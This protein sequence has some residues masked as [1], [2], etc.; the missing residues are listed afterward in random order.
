MAES[1][2][3]RGLYAGAAFA[4]SGGV[5]STAAIAAQSD[6]PELRDIVVSEPIERKKD[7]EVLFEADFVSRDE[8]TGPIVAE[9]NVRAFFG[10]RFLRADRLIYYPDTDVVIAD[11]NVSITDEKLETVFA[12]RVELTGDLRD[13]LATNFSALLAQ[14]ARLASDSA[15]RE[16]GAKTRLR[17]A[18][19]TACS[20]C[21]DEGEGKI[22]TWRLKALRVVRDEERRVLRFHHAFFELKGVP[23]LYTPLIQGPDPSVERQ[24]GFLSPRFGTSSLQ[25]FHFELPYYLAISNS[26]DATFF[27]RYTTKDG[28]LWQGEYRRRDDNAYQVLSGSIIDFDNVEDDPDA[29]SVRWHIFGKGHRRFGDNF[30]IGYDVERTSDDNFLRR[31][32]ILRR[33]DLRREIDTT[34]SNR[35]RSN[36]FAEWTN[37]PHSLKAES[38][39]FQ[40]LRRSDVD[41]LT[42]YVLPQIDYRHRGFEV[43]GGTARLNANFARLQRTEGADYQR[44][45]ASAHWSADHITKSGHKL[46]AFA[47]ARGDLFTYRDIDQGT[48]ATR[49]A[50]V[51][52]KAD[53]ETKD[54]DVRIVP[55]VGVEWSY[56]LAKQSKNARYFIEPRV[57]LVASPANV[58]DGTA[59]NEDSR[60]VEFDFANLF[61][62]NKSTGY[63]ALEDGQR[64]NVGVAASAELDAGVSIV[65]EIGQQFRLQETNA[66]N[67]GADTPDEFPN[68]LG[69]TRSDI[70]GSLNIKYRNIVG[71]NSRFRFD[72]GFGDLKRLES[73]AYLSLW[74][75]SGNA[76]YLRLAAESAGDGLNREEELTTRV[77]LRLTDHWQAGFGWRED[78]L[79]NQTIDQNFSIAYQDDCALFEIAYRRDRTLD[80]DGQTDDAFLVRFTLKSLVD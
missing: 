3:T 22:P 42:P 40:G 32:R 26:Q 74:R 12:G 38:Y 69:D 73:N 6:A 17:K 76:T 77:R 48:E 13:G 9:G 2:L 33:G 46:T 10:D 80:A 16:Q 67:F 27:P 45:S 19:Y 66:F 53:G 57:Q 54:T 20:V 78:L 15:V 63:D 51:F 50:P 29:P 4:C 35:L 41:G 7:E 60:S 8:E 23:I 72:S 52:V 30:K 31:Y 28:V 55:T 34:Q 58:N 1:L 11:G 70:V 36:G 44:L 68:G 71:V 39:V 79:A 56:P 25:G 24:S 18:V 47:E 65:G 37:G 61:D 5:V 43:A 14:N 49:G 62:Y 75:V 21:N 64:L 59:I